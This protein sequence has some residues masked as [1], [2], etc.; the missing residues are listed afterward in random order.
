M[1]LIARF[2]NRKLTLF[3]RIGVMFKID[4][5]IF[6]HHPH[7]CTCTHTQIVC[8]YMC[9]YCNICIHTCNSCVTLVR[10]H[11]ITTPPPQ[12]PVVHVDN[13]LSIPSIVVG[14]DR[15]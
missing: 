1:S 2:V 6:P 13:P 8:T 9:M 12:H 10:V 5:C 4:T 7:T 15:P 11:E 3:Y 14:E